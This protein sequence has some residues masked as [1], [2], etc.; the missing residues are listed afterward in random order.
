[1]VQAYDGDKL[2][3]EKLMAVNNNS[4]RIVE[5]DVTFDE[6]GEH[7]L[8]VGDLETMIIVE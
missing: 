5:M 4:W 2:L 6:P 8:R 7:I 3:N 1:M